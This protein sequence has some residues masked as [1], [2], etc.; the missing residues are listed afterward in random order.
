TN[1]FAPV[2]GFHAAA[3]AK[4]AAYVESPVLGSVV[5]AS[6]G[7]LTIVVSGQSTAYQIARPYLEHLGKNIFF[8]EQPGLATRIK[9]INNLLLGSFMAAISEAVALA[10]AAG[11]DKKVALDIL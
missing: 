2:E 5:P 7:A 6:Q 3:D 4:G 8:V 10:E 9:L 1:H 11:C